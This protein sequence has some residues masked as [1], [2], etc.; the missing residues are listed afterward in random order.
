MQEDR[1][2]LHGHGSLKSCAMEDMNP[3]SL[4]VT[5]RTARFNILLIFRLSVVCGC[6][7][8]QRLLPFTALTGG[9]RWLSR[10]KH[11]ASSRMVAVRFI[12]IF[13]GH[14]PSWPYYGSAVDSATDINELQEYFLALKAAGE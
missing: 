8:R 4:S 10:S 2:H 9:T 13:H 5:L 7:N 6:R 12:G 14:N 3:L 11:C 1:S